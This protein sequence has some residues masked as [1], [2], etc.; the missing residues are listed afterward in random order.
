MKCKMIIINFLLVIMLLLSGC[1]Q[2]ELREKAYETIPEYSIELIEIEIPELNVFREDSV[3]IYNVTDSFVTYSVLYMDGS[4]LGKTSYI[5]V[6]DLN[7]GKTILKYDIEEENIRVFNG[8]YYENDIFFSAVEKGESYLEWNIYKGDEVLKHGISKSDLTCPEFAY[9][10]NGILILTEDIDMLNSIPEEN[11]YEYEYAIL[12]YEGHFKELQKYNFRNT[13][14][15]Y[16]FLGR[17][18]FEVYEGTYTFCFYTKDELQVHIW[19]DSSYEIKMP[20]I[21]TIPEV[22]YSYGSLG[23]SVLDDY[24]IHCYQSEQFTYRLVA[25][26]FKSNEDDKI[27]HVGKYCRMTKINNNTMIGMS[28]DKVQLVSL[29]NGDFFAQT[30]DTSIFGDSGAKKSQKNNCAFTRVSDTQ[31]IV[32][33][34]ATN[35][36]AVLNLFY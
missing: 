8:I 3:E 29:F 33:N 18:S 26:H 25:S 13:G 31:I 14:N 7:T 23:Y 11:I 24:I 16:T 36:L 9:Y 27:G 20:L 5:G 30:I 17:D 12:Y 4:M 35:Q 10:E 22:T 21:Y 6:F 32:N 34:V 1:A 2:N 15:N 28:F 19:N